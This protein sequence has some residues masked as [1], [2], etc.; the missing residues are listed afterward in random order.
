MTDGWSHWG[1]ETQVWR[2][3]RPGKVDQEEKEDEGKRRRQAT[4]GLPQ[5]ASE[6]GGSLWH[7][8]TTCTISCRWMWSR[9]SELN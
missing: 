8:L 5:R 2:R 9:A 4:G 7:H 6:G 3:V 1:T